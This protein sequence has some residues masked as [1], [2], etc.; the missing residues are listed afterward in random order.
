M[1]YELTRACGRRWGGG[2]Q[3]GG[4]GVSLTVGLD[5]GGRALG[6]QDAVGANHGGAGT[7]TVSA[8]E[9]KVAFPATVATVDVLC[10]R[11]RGFLWRSGGGRGRAGAG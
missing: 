3:G 5:S 4:V 2:K 10:S 6:V 8:V 11:I 1:V 7:F 9:L